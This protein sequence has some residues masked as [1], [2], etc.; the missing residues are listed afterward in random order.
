MTLQGRVSSLQEKSEMIEGRHGYQQRMDGEPVSRWLL[1]TYA[2]ATTS[3]YRTRRSA[4]SRS[5]RLRNIHIACANSDLRLCDTRG[6]R[7]GNRLTRKRGAI[8]QMR[9]EKWEY[10]GRRSILAEK[11][12]LQ[13]W[14]HSSNNSRGKY[15]DWTR[16]RKHFSLDGPSSTPWRSRKTLGKVTKNMDVRKCSASVSWTATFL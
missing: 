11:F 5:G 12:L 10:H 13:Q 16:R 4:V 15:W 14:H 1:P 6:P 3:D 9:L 7:S 8:C 2:L